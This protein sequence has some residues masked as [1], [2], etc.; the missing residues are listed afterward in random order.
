[1]QILD[2]RYPTNP[3]WVFSDD[4]A[5]AREILGWLPEER[6]RFISD[7]D[8]ESASSL[9]AMRLGCAY[10]IANST[11]SWWGAYLSTSKDPTVIAPKPWFIGQKDPVNIIPENWISIN[12]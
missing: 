7:V 5:E 9:M 1:M 8:G 4:E 11:F 12:R 10:V 3:V 2:A 6:L